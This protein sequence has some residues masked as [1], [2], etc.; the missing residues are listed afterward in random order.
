[1]AG[2]A[3]RNWLDLPVDANTDHVLGPLDA[4]ITLVEYGSYACAHCSAANQRLVDIRDEF[5]ERLLYV[6]RH[7]PVPGNAL[8]RRAAELAELAETPRQ[9]WKIHSALMKYSSDLTEED[10][11]H[12]ADRFDIQTGDERAAGTASRRIEADIA[13]ADSSGVIVTPAFFI[14]GRRYDGPWDDASF[15]EALSR[16]LAHRVRVAA[17]DFVNWPP[18]TGLLLLLAAVLAVVLSNSA[19][20]PQFSAFWS[21]PA[22]FAWGDYRFVL[23]LLK[24]VNDGLLTIFFL[25]VGLEIKRE[26]TVG[27]LSTRQ[28]AAMPLAAAIGGMT[29]PAGLYLLLAPAG[30]W[31]SGWGVPIATDTAFAIALIAVMGQRVPIELRIFL[32][33]AAIADDVAVVGIIA[34]FYT[35]NLDVAW[36]LAALII[37]ALLFALNRMAVYRVAPY[38]FLGT[39]LWICIY[40]GGVHATLAGVILAFVIPTRPSPD[41]AAL[42]AQADALV[43]AE[44]QRE[45]D[46]L[47]H[48]LSTQALRAL[49]AIHNRLESPAARVLRIVEIRSSYVVLPIFALANAGVALVPGVLDQR[50]GLAIAII[51]GLF[52]GKPLGMFAASFLAVKLKLATKPDEYCWLQVA[53]AGCLGGIGFTMSLFIAGEAYPLPADFD[54]A[55]IAIFAASLLSAILGFAVL[56]WAGNR[57]TEWSNESS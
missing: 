34:F 23:P 50:G 41:F 43:A 7:R 2:E 57:R 49:E 10:L 51:G 47:R 13:S 45:D 52:V 40:Q 9:F 25:V 26:L 32:T 4:E 33:A 14:N 35:D 42:T 46:E 56:W 1:M 27:H 24:W 53:G 6:F 5:G 18:S 44:M 11:A 28:L 19:L 17:L 3:E 36:L 21:Q 16:P 12:I 48:P 38:A 22:G 54:A 20:A 55:K 31:A 39:L 15:T 30:P 29:V 8:A 37:V